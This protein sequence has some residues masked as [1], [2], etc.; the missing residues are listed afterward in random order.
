MQGSARRR[1]RIAVI[2]TAL[3]LLALEV[4][5]AIHAAAHRDDHTHASDGSIVFAHAHDAAGRHITP[6]HPAKR[7]APSSNVAFE[8]APNAHLAAGI[9]HRTVAVLDPP[10]PHIELVTDVI[11]RDVVWVATERRRFSTVVWFDSR[12][13]PAT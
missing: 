7:R 8:Q 13:P 1:R 6:H 10:S 9:A 5:P 3:W 2:T 12:G 4:L 11:V